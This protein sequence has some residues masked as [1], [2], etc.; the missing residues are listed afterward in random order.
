[1]SIYTNT[2]ITQIQSISLSNKYTR[3]Y[4]QIVSRAQERATTKKS[5]KAICEV[6]IDLHHILPKSFGLGG[7]KDPANYAYL[8]NREHLIAHWLLPKM[9]TGKFYGKMICALH[10]MQGRH[11]K[12]LPYSTRITSR[13]F[14]RLRE[15]HSKA[16]SK[17]L[18]GRSHTAEHRAKNSAAHI[19]QK[20][21]SHPKGE[22]SW[23]FGKRHS[24]ETK[25]QQ[26]VTQIGI[27]KPKF[28]CEHCGVVVGGK[29]NYIRYHGDNCQLVN[30]TKKVYKP[31][32]HKMTVCVHCGKEGRECDI[33]RSHN[34]KCKSVLNT[35]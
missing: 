24:L 23:C 27:P 35:V 13:M 18:T 10:R 17:M 3:W 22:D 11:S 16:V 20:N 21:T 28:I 30:P 9:S 34:D 25:R 1:M 7:D 31:Q 12:D 2:Y 26:S 32:K 29:S 14:A 19:G 6:A 33:N 5:A 4:C 8:T 15:Q